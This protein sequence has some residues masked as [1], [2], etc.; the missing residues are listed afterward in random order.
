MT[1]LSREAVDAA[2]LR[3]VIEKFA[4]LTKDFLR[5]AGVSEEELLRVSLA[6]SCARNAICKVSGGGGVAG[7]NPPPAGEVS[8]PP[9]YFSGGSVKSDTPSLASGTKQHVRAGSSLNGGGIPRQPSA[10]KGADEGGATAGDPL[11]ELEAS[12]ASAPKGPADAVVIQLAEL[13]Q[14]AAKLA[15]HDNE[16]KP[17]P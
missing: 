11:A 6:M 9:V 3:Q 17:Q 8:P 10:R 14:R 4:G 16:R 15:R 12:K 2:P 5:G 7:A 13:R 1:D